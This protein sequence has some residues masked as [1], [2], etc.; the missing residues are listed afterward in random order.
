[1]EPSTSGSP[2][3]TE[4]SP[5]LGGNVVVPPGG[6]S[7]DPHAAERSAQAKGPRTRR[8]KLP[9]ARRLRGGLPPLAGEG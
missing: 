7:F 5:P 1:M 4:A 6:A 9:P 8:G 2:E 3:S